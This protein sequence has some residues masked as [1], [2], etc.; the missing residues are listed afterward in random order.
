MK[1]RFMQISFKIIYF[2]LLVLGLAF[3]IGN[4]NFSFA[5]TCENGSVV[6]SGGQVACCEKFELHCKDKDGEAQCCKKKKDGSGWKCRDK[7]N[8]VYTPTCQESC[9]EKQDEEDDDNLIERTTNNNPTEETIED[10]SP[11]KE[12]NLK[13][14]VR[15]DPEKP[16]VSCRFRN[17]LGTSVCTDNN[18]QAT[19]IYPKCGPGCESGFTTQCGF[20]FNISG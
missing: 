15:L 10:Q 7:Q 8:I 2:L 18:G 1:V 19:A 4:N 6:C 20:K 9:S 13:A 14:Q 17:H 3:G 5:Q 16:G 11:E 12:D